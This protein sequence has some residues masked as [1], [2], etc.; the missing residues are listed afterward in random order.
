MG[1]SSISF[2]NDTMKNSLEYFLFCKRSTNDF[3]PIKRIKQSYVC[4]LMV[5]MDNTSS[6]TFTIFFLFLGRGMACLK[7]FIQREEVSNRF[8]RIISGNNPFVKNQFYS[9]FLP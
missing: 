6:E 7:C 4:Q 3:P 1:M 9:S 5:G 8:K 2:I